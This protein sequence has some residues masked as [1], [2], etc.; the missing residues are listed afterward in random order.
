MEGLKP[1]TQD[2]QS[3]ELQDRRRWRSIPKRAADRL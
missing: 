1:N 3:Q 2:T